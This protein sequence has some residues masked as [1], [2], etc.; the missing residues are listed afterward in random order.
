MYIVQCV[1]CGT[2]EHLDEVQEIVDKFNY[3]EIY[4]KDLKIKDYKPRTKCLNDKY[5]IYVPQQGGGQKL[6][7]R[8]TKARNDLWKSSNRQER[9]VLEECWD[10]FDTKYNENTGEATVERT[11]AKKAFQDLKNC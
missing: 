11:K 1:R 3:R 5:F 8:S 10:Y 7:N 9:V 2:G 6:S 4:Y